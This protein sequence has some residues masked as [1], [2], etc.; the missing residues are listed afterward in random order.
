MEVKNFVAAYSFFFV[1]YHNLFYP[2]AC[3]LELSSPE[4]Y[5]PNFG[6]NPVATQLSQNELLGLIFHHHNSTA[7][8]LCLCNPCEVYMLDRYFAESLSWKTSQI[9]MKEKYSLRFK[10][11]SVY[12]VVRT[13]L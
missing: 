11:A 5:H 12:G 13:N 10:L 8:E 6:L 3:I 2:L 1:K 4:V 7:L 9:N